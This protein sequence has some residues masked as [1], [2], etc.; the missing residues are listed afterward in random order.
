MIDFSWP[1]GAQRQARRTPLLL[2]IDGTDRRR[3]TLDRFI[4]PAMQAAS[5]ILRNLSPSTC[6][7]ID[8]IS[9]QGTTTTPVLW[10][11]FHDNLVSWYH[12]GKTS[13]EFI[14]ARNDGVLGCG[15]ISWTRM[16]T[17]CTSLQTDNH[18]STPS[19][20]FYNPDAV[21]DA[22]PTVSKHRRQILLSVV[23]TRISF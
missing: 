9:K 20:N 2:S 14:E 3:R 7:L 22:Q 6:L 8:S 23:I 19:L 16:Q 5:T 17:I 11:L 10:P 12:K 13:L 21:P 18:A 4:D 1:R 15:G